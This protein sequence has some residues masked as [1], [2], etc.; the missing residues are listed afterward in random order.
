MDLV[1]P[2]QEIDIKTLYLCIH[3]R[4]YERTNPTRILD[5]K[6]FYDLIGRIYHLS[7]KLGIVIMKEMEEMDMIEDLGNRRYNKI[8]IKPLFI[9]PEKNLSVLYQRM[10]IF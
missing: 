5:K 7:K 9:D 10:G 6:E 1:K 8:K 3:K 2:K 4:L